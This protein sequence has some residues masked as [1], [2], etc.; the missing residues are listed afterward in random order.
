MRFEPLAAGLAVLI[1]SAA[2]PLAQEKPAAPSLAPAVT[3]ARAAE[4]E[5]VERA[6]VTGTL[7][8][9]E[10]V[11]VAPEIEGL[12]ITEILVEEGAVVRQGDVLARLSRDII[13]ATLAQNAASIT[14]AEAAIA[15]AK[16]QIVQAEAAQV[17]AQQALERARALLKSG[18]TTEVQLE[19]RVSAARSAEGRLSAARNGLGMAEAELRSAVAQKQESDVRLARTDIRAP[20]AGIVSRKTARLGAAASASAEPLFRIIAEAEIELEGEVTETQI[21]RIR[22]GAPAQVT[23]ENG[24]VVEGRVRNVFPEIDRAT[25]LGKVR[26]ALPK[27][28]PLRIGAFAR[29]TVE[30]ARRTGI[31][32]PI[33]SVI[34]GADGPAVQVVVDNKVQARRVRTGLASDGFVQVEEG[35]AA[36]DLVVAKA[37]SFLRDGDTVRPVVADKTARAEG[38]Q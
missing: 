31:A 1:L 4:R 37:G 19:Q 12:R 25:R 7:V 13:E 9:R 35:V 11:L 8:P 29:G 10:E 27:D 17:E 15:Q 28:A 6:V 2:A 30:L 24:R 32:V 16:S 34:Y 14:R 23:V 3:V 20:R 33:A 22:E 38:A 18:N 36:G 5:V 26:I 21:G